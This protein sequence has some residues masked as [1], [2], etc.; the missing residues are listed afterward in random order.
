M[1]VVAQDV[2]LFAGTVADNLRLARPDAT[3]AQIEAAARAA[4]AHDFVTALP[5]GYDTPIGERG[6]LLSGGQRQR[7]TI[8]RA[9]LADTPVLVLDEAASHLDTENERL[10]QQALD[11]A[12]RDRTTLVIAHRLSTVRAADRIVVLDGGRVVESGTHDELLVRGGRYAG[13]VSHQTGP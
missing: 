8:A 13:L 4:R 10:V 5:R 3:D 1:T 6:A 11:A 12:R 2:H 9:L 7:L